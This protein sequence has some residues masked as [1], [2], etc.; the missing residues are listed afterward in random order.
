MR[1]QTRREGKRSLVKRRCGAYLFDELG[2]SVGLELEQH[3][4]SDAHV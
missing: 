3:D 2:V 1:W 4:V